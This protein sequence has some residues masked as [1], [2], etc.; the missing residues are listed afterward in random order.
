LDL[1]L[2]SR[3]VPSDRRNAK[4]I[5]ALASDDSSV[6]LD[7]FFSAQLSLLQPSLEG[8]LIIHLSMLSVTFIM[9]S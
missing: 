1:D 5:D 2:E 7:R 4:F 9:S 6:N 3:G 8:Y